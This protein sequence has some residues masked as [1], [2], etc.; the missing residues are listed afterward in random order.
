MRALSFIIA[1]I[2]TVL[3]FVSVAAASV[4]LLSSLHAAGVELGN[5]GVSIAIGAS[6][7]GTKDAFRNLLITRRQIPIV[8]VEPNRQIASTGFNLSC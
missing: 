3:A 5:I 2:I 8:S 1:A 7:G 6:L 4:F